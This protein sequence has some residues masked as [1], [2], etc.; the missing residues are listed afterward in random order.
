M[1][2]SGGSAV[3]VRAEADGR[4]EA[5]RIVL[6]DFAWVTWR[7]HRA[8]LVTSGVAAAVLVVTLLALAGGVAAATGCPPDAPDG[9]AAR[10]PWSVTA[11]EALL[12]ITTLGVPPLVG[13]FWGAPL[14][15]REYELGTHVLAWGQDVS[16]T[17]WFVAKTSVLAAGAAAIAALLAVATAR[18]S[19]TL[20]DYGGGGAFASGF[21]TLP[22]ESSS[23]LLVAYCVTAFAVGAAMG[24]ITRRVLPSIAATVA[25]VAAARAVVAVFLRPRFMAPANVSAPMGD[26]NPAVPRNALVL[27]ENAWTTGDGTAAEFPRDC[28]GS[29]AWETCLQAHGI[30]GRIT[31]FQ[32]PSRLVTFQWLE[33]TVFVALGLAVLLSAYWVLRRRTFAR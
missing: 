28:L 2:Q 32:P 6:R 29:A 8:L 12:R 30:V 14:V 26:V 22:F 27:V 24:T 11:A 9:C 1:T 5:R 31:I 21:A 7:Q 23:L 10:T 20:L 19:D 3:A 15:S 33:A 25:V 16:P 17:R 18:L 4:P 13:A